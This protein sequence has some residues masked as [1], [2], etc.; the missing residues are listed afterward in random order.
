MNFGIVLPLTPVMPSIPP[1][2]PIATWMP[3]PVRNPMSTV[4]DRKLAM[5]PRRMMRARI[6][7]PPAMRASRPARAMYCD[8]PAVAMPA[9]PAAI[10]AAVAESAPTTR[11]RDEPKMANDHERQDEGV[12]AGDHR[13]AGDVRVAHHLRDRQRG[14]RQ[15][16]EDLGGEAR[17]VDREHALQDRDREVSMPL[18]RMVRW[19]GVGGAR[20]RPGGDARHDG[21]GHRRQDRIISIRHGTSLVRGRRGRRSRHGA[22]LR[23]FVHGPHRAIGCLATC[24][25]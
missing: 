5:K 3:T 10:T 18:G 24:W 4:R 9:R 21:V 22:P 13:H 23:P 8:E 7:K 15:P 11:C 2:W 12:E 16:G 20:A 6:M 1:S 17:P 19:G 14:E 25:R